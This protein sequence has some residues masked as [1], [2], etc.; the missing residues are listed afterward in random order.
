VARKKAQ[1]EKIELDAR[2]KPEGGEGTDPGR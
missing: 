1:K 2:R